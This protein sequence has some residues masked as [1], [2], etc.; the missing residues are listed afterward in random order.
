MLATLHTV[1]AWIFVIGNGA[2]ATWALIAHGR[3]EFR[4]RSLWWLTAAVQA[5]VSVQL[6]L[7]VLLMQEDGREPGDFHVLYG[8]VAAMSV[9]ILFSYRSQL[10][11]RLYLLYG[12]G[13][14]FVMG[15]GIRTMTLTS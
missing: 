9:G 2:A 11:D 6:L 5:W 4:H 8:A 15:L 12:L 10:R 14:L 1:A 7:G 13:G 3:P